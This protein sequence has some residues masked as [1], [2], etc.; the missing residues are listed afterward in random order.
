MIVAK[1]LTIG[2]IVGAFMGIY[3]MEE[4]RDRKKQI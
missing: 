3:I 2:V 4:I 1:V